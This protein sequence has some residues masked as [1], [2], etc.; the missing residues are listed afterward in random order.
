M[1]AFGAPQ[2]GQSVALVVAVDASGRASCSISA[3]AFW[4][5]IIPSNPIIAL[6][7][8]HY[9]GF[10]AIPGHIG[11]DKIEMGEARSSIATPMPTTC[12]TNISR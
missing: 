6:Y 3:S 2:F 4:H 9:A 10:G 7:Q 1:G 12:T 8:L 5:L 11:F